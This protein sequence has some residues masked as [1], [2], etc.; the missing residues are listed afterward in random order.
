MPF[1]VA[2]LLYLHASY[3]WGAALAAIAPRSAR[4]RKL[5][6]DLVGRLGDVIGLGLAVAGYYLAGG[7]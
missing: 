6:P 7:G 5:G 1:A 2:V 3:A 4:L